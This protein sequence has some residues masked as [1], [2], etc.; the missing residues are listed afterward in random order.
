MPM[1]C[2]K[3]ANGATGG[4]S[5]CNTIGVFGF[6]PPVF[7]GT[8][9]KPNSYNDPSKA[10]PGRWKGKQP[11]GS[12]PK[13]GA[14]SR[15][16]TIGGTVTNDA[17]FEK[18]FQRMYEKDGY[19]GDIKNPDERLNGRAAYTNTINTERYRETL[20]KEDRIT[21]GN[22]EKM[23]QVSMANLKARRAEDADQAKAQML[24]A[25]VR[26]RRYKPTS[27]ALSIGTKLHMTASCNP[28][29]YLPPIMSDGKEVMPAAYR[30]PHAHRRSALTEKCWFK[31]GSK[32][33][34]AE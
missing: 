12:V 21:G 20:R 6:Q 10:L 23:A 29:N 22:A 7:V 9:E 5:L 13:R 1:H 32:A 19:S 15:L 34:P 33:A 8:K 25:M 3:A 11:L 16:S 27:Q 24:D 4:T 18:E 2:G 30:N 28:Q 26:D 17:L 31:M 14:F